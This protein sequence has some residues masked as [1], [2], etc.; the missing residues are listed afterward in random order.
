M[1]ALEKIFGGSARVK[2]MRLF[3][4]NSTLYFETSDV[5]DRSKVDSARARKELSFLASVGMVKKSSRNGTKVVWY[6]NDKF[7]YLAEFQQLLLQTSLIN[8]RQHVKK[9]AKIGKLKLVVFGGL[10]KENTDATLD[11]MIVAEGAKKSTAESVMSSLE[12]EIGT[13]IR[14]VVLDSEDFRYRLGVG[15]K[16]IRDVFDY[17]HEVVLDRL[18]LPSRPRA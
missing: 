12:A 9:M 2:L 17:P 6:L 3:M 4:F 5:V 8:T 14:Y 16:L 15:D 13:E 18:P 7:P 10:F 1:D 11:I